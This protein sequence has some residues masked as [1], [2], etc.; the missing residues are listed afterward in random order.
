MRSRTSTSGRSPAPG[1]S[2]ASTARTSCIRA[3]PPETRRLRIVGGGRLARSE[4]RRPC[5][6]TSATAYSVAAKWSGPA[7]SRSARPCVDRTPGPR[8][9]TGPPR[10]HSSASQSRSKNASAFERLRPEQPREA[11]KRHLAPPGVGELR[12]ARRRQQPPTKPTSAPGLPDGR[13]VVER[14][15]SPRRRGP[16]ALRRSGPSSRQNGSGYVAVSLIRLPPVHALASAAWPIR[17]GLARTRSRGAATEARRSPRCRARTWSELSLAI[18]TPS[19][20][21]RTCVTRWPVRTRSPSA[22]AMPLGDQ[23]RPAHDPVL[24]RAALDVEELLEA[25][26]RAM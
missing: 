18:S 3:R 20:P 16:D 17:A 23:R 14:D 15:A 25:A 1:S 9:E 26:A 8:F 13:R 12:V 24:L 2:R 19:S 21:M 11:A 5:S 7:G 6:R 10:A 4:P 22:A